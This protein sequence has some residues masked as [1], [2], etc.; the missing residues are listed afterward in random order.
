MTTHQW[1]GLGMVL[2]AVGVPVGFIF[3]SHCR[4]IGWV[5]ASLI[6]LGLTLLG[7]MMMVGLVLL[8]G[9]L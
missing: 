2:G 4:R 5:A 7:A 9:G 1:I 3:L 8:S 6:W